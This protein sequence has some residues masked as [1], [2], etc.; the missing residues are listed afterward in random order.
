M[1]RLVT[2][3]IAALIALAV[4]AIPAS[5]RLDHHFSVI[6]KRTSSHRSGDTFR[7]TEKLFATFNRNDQVGHDQV[8]CHASRSHKFKCRATVHLNGEVG[9]SGSLRVNGNIGRGDNRLNLVGGTGDFGGAA[10]KVVTHGKRLH[11]DVIR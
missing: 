8:R 7:F 11:F 3:A 9:G 4:L 10:G 1:S 5:A 6:T 2:A